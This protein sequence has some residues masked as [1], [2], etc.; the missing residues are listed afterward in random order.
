MEDTVSSSKNQRSESGA[1]KPHQ[2]RRSIGESPALTTQRLGDLLRSY[3]SELSGRASQR[4]DL[5]IKMWPQVVGSQISNMTKACKFENRTLYVSVKNS[6]LLSILS[7]PSDKARLV[8]ELRNFI[9]GIDIDN[10]VFKFG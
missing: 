3:L 5:V 1:N 9:P 10:I 2:T 6:T 4:P 8:Q 7:R